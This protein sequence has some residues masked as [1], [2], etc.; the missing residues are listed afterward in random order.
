MFSFT[1]QAWKHARL[2]VAWPLHLATWV[3]LRR[4]SSRS[5]PSSH[6]WYSPPQQRKSECSS[7]G[8]SGTGATCLRGSTPKTNPQNGSNASTLSSTHNQNSRVSRFCRKYKSVSQIPCT[9]APASVP[10]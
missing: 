10:L 8:R 6:P 4:G 5:C 7:T 1:I 9:P 3:L 2:R